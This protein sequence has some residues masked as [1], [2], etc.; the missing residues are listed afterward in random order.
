MVRD[1]M[2]ELDDHSA[3]QAAF[4]RY[5]RDAGQEP[6]D[7]AQLTVQ[8]QAGWDCIGMVDQVPGW[9]AHLAGSVLRRC[10]RGRATP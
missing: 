10:R 1:R 9:F 5:Y 3:G 7:W 4:A 6:P 8:D 2:A